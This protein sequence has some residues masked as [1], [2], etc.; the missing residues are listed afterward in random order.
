VKQVEEITDVLSL[1]WGE[2]LTS[3]S[4][5]APVRKGVGHEKNFFCLL[6]RQDTRKL[7]GKD[8]FFQA[9]CG[10]TLIELI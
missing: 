1:S 9:E 7:T 8:L 5:I 10:M 4:V 2:R 3:S 6:F